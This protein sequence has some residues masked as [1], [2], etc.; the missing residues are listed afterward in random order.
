VRKTSKIS[1]C[2]IVKNEIDGCKKVIPLINRKKF[3][4]IFAINGFSTDGT[5]EFLIS[6]KIKVYD[7]VHKGLNNAYILANKVSRFENI[8]VF[9]PKG[10]INPN[11][12]LSFRY[13]FDN[14]YQFIVASRLLKKSLNEEDHKII[15]IRKWSV[16]IL[17]L[18]ISLIWRKEGS[19]IWD[20]LHGVKGWKKDLFSKM[21][22]NKYGF[23]IDLEMAIQ[24]YKLKLKRIEFPV[25]EHPIIGRKTNFPFFKTGFSILIFLLKEIFTKKNKLI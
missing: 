22:I 25:R 15:K 4:E 8:V 7:Q 12:T 20:V 5:K 10:S 17:S 3:G 6:K 11:S 2:L 16:I 21:A 1:L 19:I 9:F 23:T 14:N 18:F 13:Y 24:A